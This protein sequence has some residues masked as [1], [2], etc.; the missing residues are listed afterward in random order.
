MQMFYLFQDI[1][2]A[3]WQMMFH[4]NFPKMS[5]QELKSDSMQIDASDGG[6]IFGFFAGICQFSA[7]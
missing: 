3:A 4:K 5:A 7:A 1:F 6:S 2:E